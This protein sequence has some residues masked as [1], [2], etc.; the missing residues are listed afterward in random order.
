MGIHLLPFLGV[1][2][3]VIVAPGPDT[4]V[5]T[6]NGLLHG[7]RLGLATAFGVNCGLLVWTVATA[8]GLAALV[9]ASEVA[10]TVLKFVG[11][12]YL[13][14]LGIQALR[15]RRTATAAPGGAGGGATRPIS[16]GRGFRQGLASNLSNPKIALMFTSLLPQFVSPGTP[17]LRPFLV[18]GGVFVAMTLLWLCGYAVVAARAARLLQRPRVARAIDGVTGVVLIGFGLRLA[19]ERR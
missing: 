14:W 8:S 3:V 9:R 5:V 15:A 13:I 11:A 19:T 2:A 12:A 16:A 7:R 10:F 6:K 1:A 17:V 18:L 4:A